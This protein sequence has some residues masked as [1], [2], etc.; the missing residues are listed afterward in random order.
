ME[1]QIKGNVVLS[2]GMESGTSKSGKQWS[3]ASIVIETEGQ[4][5]KKVLLTNFKSAEKFAGLQP[6]TTG[7]FHIEI[8]S[9]EYNGRWYT[10]VNCYKW[11]V[12]Q[13]QQYAPQGQYQQQPMPPQGAQPFYGPAPEYP[14][15]TQSSTPNLDSLGVRGYQQPQS[16]PMPAN[17]DD[18][19]PF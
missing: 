13:N 5:P 7:T 6:G 8:S 19:L 15:N 17:G 9:D 18:D 14:V 11:E 3:K 1:L 12:M 10:S 16:A 2:L 4:Y